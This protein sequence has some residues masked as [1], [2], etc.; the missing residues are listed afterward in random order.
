MTN[1][2]VSYY[3]GDGVEKNEEEAV[4]WFELAAAQDEPTALSNLGLCH[5]QGVGVPRA[6]RIRACEFLARAAEQ[7]HPGASASL[8]ELRVDADVGDV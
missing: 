5:A 6:D 1:L 2:G 4:K 7:G 3:V 8:D